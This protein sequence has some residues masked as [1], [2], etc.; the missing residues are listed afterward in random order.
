MLLDRLNIKKDYINIYNNFF[1]S[2]Y[3]KINTQDINQIK[4]KK[5][6]SYEDACLYAYMKNMLDGIDYNTD[7]RQVII[8][9]AQDYTKMQYKLLFSIFK[10]ANFTILGDINQTINPYYKYESLNILSNY[11]PNVRYIE[12]LKT[13]RSSSEIIEYTNK[14]LNLNHISAIRRE[15]KKEVI[16]RNNITNLKETIT[17]DIKTLQKQYK[18]VAIITKT[19]EETEFIYNL[20]KDSIPITKID[21]NSEEYQRDLVILPSYISKGLEFDSVIVYTDPKNKYTKDEKYL[22][23]VACTR[24]QHQL[25][26]Y[27][28]N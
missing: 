17:N 26:V 16:E 21:N 1:K 14:I 22:F 12:L 27:N 4:N 18:S 20:I 7:I 24:C 13:Y 15:N 3:S 2:K 8:D 9:E 25:I 10:N 19:L 28:Q 23:Y 6:I 11:L 5:L